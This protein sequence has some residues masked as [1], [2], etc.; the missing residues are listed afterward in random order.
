MLDRR[1]RILLPLSNARPTAEKEE[2]APWF[3]VYHRPHPEYLPGSCGGRLVLARLTPVPA[4]AQWL[5]RGPG[6]L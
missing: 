5:S 3:L 6:S 1:E 2:T 4:T